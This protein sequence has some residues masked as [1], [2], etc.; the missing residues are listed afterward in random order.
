MVLPWGCGWEVAA[1][2]VTRARGRGVAQRSRAPKEAFGHCQGGVY[3]KGWKPASSKA[4][5][6]TA[7]LGK[8][9]LWVMRSLEASRAKADGGEPQDM[10]RGLLFQDKVLCAER[11]KKDRRRSCQRGSRED[12]LVGGGW[13]RRGCQ[14][15]RWGSLEPLVTAVCPPGWPGHWGVPYCVCVHQM[16][17][18]R[19]PRA[20]GWSPRMPP[21]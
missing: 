8:G 21:G 1:A 2:E 15:D 17:W 3:G 18:L 9:L 14:G 13:S 12:A 7:Q 20:D 5:V 6:A 10:H 4:D 11:V 19:C 16:W